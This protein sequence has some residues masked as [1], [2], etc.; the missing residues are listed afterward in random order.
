MVALHAS[1]MVAT[2]SA[3]DVLADK[4]EGKEPLISPA[5]GGNAQ[6]TDDAIIVV[7]RLVLR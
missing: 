5:D 4:G 2:V 3:G 1:K 7:P 6:L